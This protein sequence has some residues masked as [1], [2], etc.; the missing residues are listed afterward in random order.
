NYTYKDKFLA[1][2]SFRSDGSSRYSENSKW[3]Y[4]PS[5]SVAWRLSEEEFIKNISGISDLKLRIGYGESGSTALSPYQTLNQLNSGN[6]VFGDALYT[7]YA[8]GS[9]MPGDLKWETTSQADIGIDIGIIN[10][11]LRFTADYYIKKTRDLLN[12]VQL[13][14]SL[15]YTTTIANVGEIENKGFEFAVDANA[16]TGAFRWD[17]SANISF[18][19]NQV[20]KLYDGKDV[21]GDPINITVVNDNINILREGEPLGMFFGYVEKGY[22]DNGKIIYEDYNENGL[23]DLGDKRIIGNP[24]P[25]FIFGFNSNMFFKNFELNIFIQGS[26][27]NDIF[28]LSS[29][30][31]TLDYGFGLNMPREVLDRKCVV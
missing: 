1:T 21:L 6:V 25:D 22:D 24:N 14:S 19:R 20:L 10:N 23:R 2:V 17:I 27:G 4:F 9:R 15:G 29:V 3:G 16:L 5:A 28:N 8:P 26:Q 7:S 11:R 12:N 18:N 31:Q 30:N 13:P